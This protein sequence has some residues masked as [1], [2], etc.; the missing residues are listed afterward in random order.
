MP[1]G[2]VQEKERFLAAI[3]AEGRSSPA[4]MHWQ[5]F[6]EFLRRSRGPDSSDPPVPLI[7][8][9]SG[10]SHHAKHGRLGEQL[11][12]AIANGVFREALVFLR[13]IPAENWNIGSTGKWHSEYWP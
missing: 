4:G 6:H 12:W 11:D 5:G 2:D 3:K 10:A 7:L 9:A 13:G 1:T 8:A